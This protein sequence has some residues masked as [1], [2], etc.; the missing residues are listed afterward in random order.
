MHSDKWKLAQKLRI[1][2]IQFTKHVKLKNKEDQSVDILIFL[3]MGNKIPMEG[4]T[5]TKCEAET[6]VLTIQ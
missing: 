4:V 6:K 1:H 3:K 5:E 2:K